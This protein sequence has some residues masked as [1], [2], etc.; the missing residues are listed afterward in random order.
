MIGNSIDPIQLGEESGI[1]PTRC[2]FA[3][4]GT[5]MALLSSAKALNRAYVSQVKSASIQQPP[6]GKRS[7]WRDCS[8]R[9]DP[10]HY[11]T[12]HNLLDIHLPEQTEIAF[13]QT[14]LLEAML[15]AEEL[16]QL[17]RM[18]NLEV[19]ADFMAQEA[20]AEGRVKDLPLGMEAME[21]RES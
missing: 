9:L 14:L 17:L 1:I 2:R 16:L 5:S 4:F 13:P 10:F 3:Y 7:L 8:A 21:R 20:E 6:F 15:A 12:I 11:H 18:V 19:M